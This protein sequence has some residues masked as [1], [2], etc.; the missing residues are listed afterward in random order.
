MRCGRMLRSVSGRPR[1]GPKTGASLIGQ[2]E[3]GPG[4]VV[5]AGAVGCW[6]QRRQRYRCG[7]RGAYAT[8]RT[9]PVKFIRQAGEVHLSGGRRQP[10]LS[11]AS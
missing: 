6:R 3:A 10:P 5:G 7:G 2:P 9:R 4:V 11:L 8:R 1:A